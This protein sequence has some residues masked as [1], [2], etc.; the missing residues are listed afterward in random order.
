MQRVISTVSAA[1]YPT[2]S[3]QVIGRLCRCDAVA[4]LRWAARKLS[5]GKL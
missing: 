1:S 5:A 4:K 2:K 3:I